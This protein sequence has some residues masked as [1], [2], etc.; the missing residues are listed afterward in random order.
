MISV[1]VI[2]CPR[3]GLTDSVELSLPEGSTLGQALTASGLLDRHAIDAG[4]VQAGI[5]ARKQP[6]DAPLRDRD[7][8]EIYR[9]LQC[10]PKEARRL[11][12]RQRADT[13]AKRLTGNPKR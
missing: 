6:M 13:E 7:R 8:V 10:D 4:T 9:P 1:E 12:Y 3:P 5:W 11:R 2:Y